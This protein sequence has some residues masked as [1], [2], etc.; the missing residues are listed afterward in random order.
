MADRTIIDVLL[1]ELE[2]E[3][4]NVAIR[5]HA[6]SLLHDNGASQEAFSLVVEGLGLDPANAE[7]LAIGVT[8]GRAAGHHQQADGYA[9]LL[10]ALTGESRAEPDEPEPP[11]AAPLPA[12][13]PTAPDTVDDLLATWADSDA[14]EE[15]EIG[16]LSM[17]DTM[18]T[19]VGGMADVKERLELSFLGPMKNPELQAAFGKSLRGGLMLWG[20]PGCGKTFI[21]RAVA[22]EL[23][24]KFYEVGLAD[25]LDMWIGSSERNLRSIFEVARNNTPCVLFF[26]E[27]DA[28]GMKRSEL[29][30]GGS[31]MRG[32]VNQLLTELDGVSGN[33]DG[34]FVLAATNHPW[35]VDPAL[36]RPGRLDRSLLVLPPDAA[37]RAAVLR[38]HLRGR[39]ADEVDVDKIAAATDG[40]TG[41]DM[42]LIAEQATED[43]LAASMK[44]GEIKPITTKA[45][46]KA[47]K[48]VRPSI[49]S[50]M[51][52]ARNHATFGN[53]DG[54]YDELAQ[55]LRK[56]R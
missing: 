8:S 53:V 30:G 24:A 6:A 35:D 21:A 27:I 32:V 3:P 31:A 40:L 46:A 23:G 20:P 2:R 45:L 39:P 42:A 25:V 22:G 1:A 55:Y 5:A 26:D 12:G 36:L 41:A 15:P 43:S 33:N 7:L 48:G 17:S 37:A 34:V 16:H 13:G 14:L 18:L 49:G 47:A 28:L 52:T 19:D 10:A 51:E 9:T 4:S 29:R 50:W 44:A 56:R 38:Y 11:R 54:M